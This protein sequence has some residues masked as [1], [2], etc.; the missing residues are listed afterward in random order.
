MVL[1]RHRLW[2][3]TG[4]IPTGGLKPVM[5]VGEEHEGIRSNRRN[6]DW[7]IETIARWLG[8]QSDQV[9]TGVIPTGGL[10]QGRGGRRPGACAGSNRRNPDWGIETRGTRSPNRRTR[11]FKPA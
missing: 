2:V 11:L 1:E 6:P 9:Q 10:K 8:N 4:V 5:V 7:G 3:Q